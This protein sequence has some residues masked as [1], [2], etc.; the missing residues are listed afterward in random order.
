M[1][2]GDALPYW[3]AEGT[4]EC[5]ICFHRYTVEVELRCADCDAPLCE[6][7]ALTVRVTGEVFCVPCHEA[8]G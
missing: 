5:E 6:Q 4:E 3:L 7:C 8:E 2:T 1:S